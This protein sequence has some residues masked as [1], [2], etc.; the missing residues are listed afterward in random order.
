LTASA[1]PIERAGQMLQALGSMTDPHAPDDEPLQEAVLEN[2]YRLERRIGSGGMGTVYLAQQLALRIPVAIKVLHRERSEDFTSNFRLLRE[3]RVAARVAHPN[4]T[5]VLDL[6][7]TPDGLVFSVMEYLEGE[8]LSQRL[9]REGMLPW[10]MTRRILRQVVRGLRAAHAIGVV[11]RDI[12]PSNVFLVAPSEARSEQVK[13]LDFGLAKADDPTRT[14]GENLTRDAIIGTVDYIAPERVLGQNA[15]VR[16]DIYSLGVMM[17][18]MLTGRRPWPRENSP[19]RAMIRRAKEEPPPLPEG[20]PGVPVE[21][22]E[23]VR[24]AMARLPEDRYATLRELDAALRDAASR[25]PPTG[26]LAAATAEPPSPA[27]AKPAKPAGE[28][29]ASHTR[30]WTGEPPER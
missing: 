4:V 2:R 16:S 1:V 22:R 27:P 23:V 19:L 6:G 21:M 29:P 8:D 25:R 15:D 12:K 3:A 26:P 5:R 28:A 20:L 10:S 7:R 24:R 14:F 13:L 30:L 17:F 9:A 11:H 18:E